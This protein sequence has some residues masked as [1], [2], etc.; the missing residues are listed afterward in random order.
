MPHSRRWMA[1]GLLLALLDFLVGGGRFCP[2]AD[3]LAGGPAPDDQKAKDPARGKQPNS[4]RVLFIGNSLTASNNLP[5]IVQ[6]MAKAGGQRPLVYQTE[7]APG[8]SLG[9]HLQRGQ[10]QRAIARGK[11]DVV[12]LQHGPSTLPESR[13][14]L[15]RDA[16]RFNE[17][18]RKAG[19][20]PAL[21]MVW[22][23]RSRQQDFDR[24]RDS[25]ALAAKETEGILLPAGEAWRAALLKQ[26]NLP[27]YNDDIH[28]TPAGSYLAALVI[29]ARLYEQS[30]VG[31]P[32]TLT[33]APGAAIRLSDAQAKMFQE[34][35]GQANKK[36][37]DS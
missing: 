27:L 7:V 18:I 9:D 35:A 33:L 2:T 13:K 11:W 34:A 17:L 24:V 30:P 29:Y 8:F 26:P 10:A 22:P 6:A 14:E 28:P 19:A 12:V 16:R 3:A 20:R 21:L 36:L 4:L 5:A 37:G 25:Y 15:V 31:L 1:M 32:A 23:L